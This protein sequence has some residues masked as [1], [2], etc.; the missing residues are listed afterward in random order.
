MPEIRI[1][2]S[3]SPDSQDV[4]I[5]HPLLSHVAAGSSL[6]KKG[7]PKGMLR[8]DTGDHISNKNRT[9]CELTAQYWAWKNVEVDYYGFC[10]YRR[11]FS[12]AP[13]RMREE[14][15][16]CLIFPYISPDM[17]GKLCMGEDHIRR[18]VEGSDCLI[19]QGIPVHA[20]HARSVYDHYQKAD[21][22]HVRDLDLFL[23]I[24]CR[25]YPQLA[26]AARSY[27]HGR[28]FYPC[29]MF[30]MKK[31]V[32]QDYAS[33]LFDLLAEFEAEA[34]T[35]GYSREGLRTP[36]HL[37]ER[38]AGIY[39]TYLKQKGGYCLGELQMAMVTHTQACT[40]AKP[41]AGEI[42]VV[43]AA[44]RQFVP[45]LAVCLRSLADHADPGRR[46]HIYVLHTDIGQADQE[47]LR[48]EY[49][50]GHIRL[51]FMNAGARADGYRLRAKG[52][53]SVQTYY[54]FLIPEI[55]RDCER[56]VYLDADLVIRKD[57]AGLY[58]LPSGDAMLAAAPDPDFIGQC[59][60]AN[61][62]TRS[63]QEQVLRLKDPCGYVQAG[64]LVFYP[65]AWGRD[66]R[67]RELFVMAQRKD[68][69][70]SDQDILNIV[71]EGRIQRLDIKW[72]VLTDSG[73]RRLAVIRSAPAGI[74]EEYEQ[75]RREAYIIHY[76]GGTKPWHNPYEDYG[77]EFWE[78]ARRTP[79][80]EILLAGI[81]GNKENQTA[82]EK[83]TDLARRAAKAVLP[84]GSWIR[85]A[86]GGWYWRLK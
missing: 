19:A 81:R 6:W 58:D 43:L 53:I 35:D 46:Y 4:C 29:N 21:G 55:F 68:Y 41:A 72:N 15:C 20:L 14:D 25:R 66:F 44:D 60:G 17:K 63:Y 23:S 64:V 5:R 38:F 84:R 16:G 86:V 71:C 22:L 11:Y 49:A 85:R 80:Y 1:F 56:V 79:Y 33:M 75:A 69:R 40:A 8:D 26:S 50:C 13:H 48:Q 67:A 83:T 34:D 10:H 30:L 12:F 28:V 73:G 82:A 52:H 47:A 61:P 37:G 74:Q 2:V 59:C 39:Y 70:Y 45:V 57:I 78:A 51:D 7:V 27:I 65:K 31:E 18:T 9:Y 76:A 3:H 54:R 77:K 62:D 32:F 36:G 24:L 42:P